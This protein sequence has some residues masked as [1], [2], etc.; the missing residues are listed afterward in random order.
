[1][2]LALPYY[3]ALHEEWVQQ[4][5]DPGDPS[6]PTITE[7]LAADFMTRAGEMRTVLDAVGTGPTQ[8]TAVWTQAP[9]EVARLDRT[10]GGPPVEAVRA[11]VDRI[12]EA[13]AIPPD[14]LSAD[15]PRPMPRDR[16]ER[17]CMYFPRTQV[18]GFIQADAT[19]RTMCGTCAFLEGFTFST[20]AE[21][22]L[23][24]YVDTSDDVQWDPPSGA[25]DAD[26]HVD[27][28]QC[29]RMLAADQPPVLHSAA[30]SRT[31]CSAAC[32]NAWVERCPVERC[33]ACG[34]ETVDYYYEH[35][36]SDDDGAASVYCGDCYSRRRDDDE[37]RA[38][39]DE[40]NAPMF[41]GALDASE[42]L[43]ARSTHAGLSALR[44]QER[45]GIDLRRIPTGDAHD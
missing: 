25:V 35:F 9:R 13:T 36:A 24:R 17:C 12:A 8:W 40:A 16:C 32:A 37:A 38:S 27:C 43:R 5:A 30:G 45:R 20:G 4:G 33:E 21:L 18:R 3:A 14:I 6:W 31:F 23:S 2:D 44:H 34:V 15:I 7:S 29:Q 28:T 42:S 39:V 22:G 19:L 26:T 10:D 1:M 41:R 11:F